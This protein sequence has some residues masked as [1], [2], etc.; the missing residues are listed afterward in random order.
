MTDNPR[1][2]GFSSIHPRSVAVTGSGTAEAS[3]DLLTLTVGVECRRPAVDAAY[4]EAARASSAITGVLRQQGIADSDI[5]TSGLNIRAEVSWQEGR[6]QLIS[7]YL[8]SSMLS[9]RLRDLAASSGLIA[10]A[11][12]AGGDDVRLNGVELG[13]ADPAAVEARAREAAWNDALTRAEHFAALAGSRLGKTL[14]VTQQF[15][16]APPLPLAGLQ[17]AV[18]SEP[19]TVETGSAG[20]TA[21][22][23]VVWELLD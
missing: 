5:T 13:F 7:G 19:L 18:A 11:V 2:S 20:V 6:G 22:V 21:A 3:P 23:G 15:P 1:S 17:R 16:A 12:A 9:V 8:A 4:R 14:S 10:A